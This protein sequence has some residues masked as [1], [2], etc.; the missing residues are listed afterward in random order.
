MMTDSRL[1]LRSLKVLNIFLP[2]G[3]FFLF[4]YQGNIPKINLL[5][6]LSLLNVI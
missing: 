3:S 2:Y 4:V 6:L 1:E 5:N